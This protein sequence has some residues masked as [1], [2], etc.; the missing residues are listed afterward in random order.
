[1]IEVPQLIIGA[2][3]VYQR[4]GVVNTTP[5]QLSNSAICPKHDPNDAMLMKLNGNG[6]VDELED[7]PGHI[8]NVPNGRLVNN[9]GSG[10]V[11]TKE[12]LSVG[13]LDGVTARVIAFD[14]PLQNDRLLKSSCKT[15]NSKDVRA[16]M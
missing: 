10:I 8:D 7:P 11:R 9:R 5:R 6:C 13:V 15:G 16:D 3:I 14:M 2:S 1:M 4:D 12:L